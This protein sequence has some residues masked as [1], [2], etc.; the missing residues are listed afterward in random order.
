MRVTYVAIEAPCE[1]EGQMEWIDFQWIVRHA[2]P[3]LG[4]YWTTVC[5]GECEPCALCGKT[6]PEMP[7]DFRL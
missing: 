6:L 7:A 5:G 3:R 4:L 2:I 1:C